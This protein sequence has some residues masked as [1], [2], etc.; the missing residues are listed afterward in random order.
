MAARV[1]LLEALGEVIV[2]NTKLLVG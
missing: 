2:I 1:D